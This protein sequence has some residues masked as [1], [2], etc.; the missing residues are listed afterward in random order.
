ML[1]DKKCKGKCGLVKPLKEYRD[2]RSIC[3][4]C[5]IERVKERTETLK[6][7]RETNLYRI[8]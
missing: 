4:K 2:G 3:R 7:Q 5:E 1:T 8:F 6:K